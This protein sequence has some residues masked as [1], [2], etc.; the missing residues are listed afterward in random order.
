MKFD[1][2]AVSKKDRIIKTLIFGVPAAIL[3]G[4]IGAFAIRL[5]ILMSFNIIYY[6]VVLGIGYIMGNIVKKIGRGTTSEFLVIAA[7]LAVVSILIAM[8]LY[9]VIYYGAESPVDFIVSMLYSIGS[10]N[11]RLSLLEV[12]AGAAVAV[13]QANTVQIR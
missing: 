4:I 10:F 8:Y 12:I 7:I 1:Y 6:I 3:L 2:H 11:S 13:Y 5:S 9:T